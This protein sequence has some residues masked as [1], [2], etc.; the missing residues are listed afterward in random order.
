MLLTDL[1]CNRTKFISSPGL[2]FLIGTVVFV[3]IWFIPAITNVAGYVAKV[4]LLVVLFYIV[5]TNDKMKSI[6]SNRYATIIGGMCYSIYLLHFGILALLGRLLQKTSI[7]LS[8][9][10]YVP[11]YF[12]LFVS[13]ILS[14]SGAY[15]LLI[16]KPFMR[17][18]FGGKH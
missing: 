13:A 1:Y 15:F 4:V 11:L 16:E 9:A 7:N 8:N 14:I 17:L 18:R 10:A 6:F 12:L 2:C 3:A 5:L